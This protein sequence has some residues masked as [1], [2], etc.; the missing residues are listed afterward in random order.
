MNFIFLRVMEVWTQWG[1]CKVNVMPLMFQGK[2]LERFAFV[3]FLRTTD[4]QISSAK[5]YISVVPIFLSLDTADSGA[6]GPGFETYRRRVVSLSKTL[7]SPKVLVNYPGSDDWKIVDWD[8]KP[9]HNQPTNLDT[10]LGLFWR[11]WQVWVWHIS[12]LKT[13]KR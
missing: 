13:R 1:T 7:Y 4:L 6:R 5:K 12:Y 2:E 3:S 9:Q 8:V 10:A 11:W